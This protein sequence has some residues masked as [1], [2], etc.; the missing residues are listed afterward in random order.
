MKDP[1]IIRAARSVVDRHGA[2]AEMHAARKA[3][4]LREAGDI[5][6]CR[7]WLR[8][9]DVVREMQAAPKVLEP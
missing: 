5:D 2:D 9:I 3:D 8:I 6:G 4:G 7:L 1:E